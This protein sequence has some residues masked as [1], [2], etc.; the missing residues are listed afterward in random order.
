MSDLSYTTTIFAV[1]QI[2]LI[3]SVGF[4]LVKKNIIDDKG[5]TLLTRLAVGLFYPLFAFDQLIGSFDFRKNPDWWLYPAIFLVMAATAFVVSR[6]TLV[7]YPSFRFKKEL[8]VLLMYQNCGYIPLLL[9]S[10]VFPESLR[11]EMFIKIFLFCMGF[12]M[13]LWTLGVWFLTSHKTQKQEF[14]NLFNPP[15]LAI[16]FALAFVFFGWQGK[17]PLVL[18]NPIAMLGQCALPI[19]MM[20][21][22][23]NLATINIVDTKKRDVVI[24]LLGKL[25]ILPLLALGAVWWL[26]PDYLLGFLIVLQA[27][28]PS[29]MTLS[30][31]ARYYRTEEKFINQSIFY[32]HLFSVISI[33]FFLILYAHLNKG[34]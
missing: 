9:T 33:P 19:G 5:L 29:A 18:S 30:V 23:A 1:A 2:F 8:A 16:V 22:G 27:A 6:L 12:D 24:V 34:N 25:V 15:F 7:F 11:Q 31:V 32:S 14:K 3:G 10:A 4:L 28:T 13:T 26:K 20:V 17:I 21:V